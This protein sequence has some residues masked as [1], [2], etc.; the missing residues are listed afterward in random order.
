ME[1]KDNKLTMKADELVALASSLALCLSKKYSLSD[2]CTIRQFLSTLSS[3]IALIEYQS[4]IC[5][6]YKDTDKKNN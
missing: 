4:K 6:L 3:N 2:L 1:E 5:R